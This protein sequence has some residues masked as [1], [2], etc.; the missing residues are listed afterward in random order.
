MEDVFGL[1]GRAG[2]WFAAGW[3]SWERR[4]A[5]RTPPA[6]RNSRRSREERSCFMETS[7]NT[8]K[9]EWGYRSRCGHGLRFPSVNTRSR[10]STTAKTYSAD[11]RSE[12]NETADHA[13]DKLSSTRVGQVF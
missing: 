9:G 2:S 11:F 13:F 12:R 4:P 1:V 10:P 5:A 8:V 7:T 6:V 3:A